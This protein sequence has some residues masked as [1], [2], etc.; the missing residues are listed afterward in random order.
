MTLPV[1]SVPKFEIK[2]PG[3]KTPIS[4]RP[5]LVKE[6]KIL[7]MLKDADPNEVTRQ[8][9]D[10]VETCSF[11]AIKRDAPYYAI[12]YAFTQLRAKSIGEEVALQIECGVNGC[13]EKYNHTMNLSDTL[14]E[15]T[16]RDPKINLGGS[17]G[18]VL[19]FPTFEESVKV[20]ESKDQLELYTLLLSL[21]RAVYTDDTYIEVSDVSPQEFNQFCESLSSEHV[22]QIEDFVRNAPI[23]KN[24]LNSKCPACG[25]E[26]EHSIEGLYLFFV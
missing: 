11:G 23:V 10:L 15:G 14:V 24:K 4:M 7:M 2:V 17:V 12:T 26:H 13:G 25:T 19:R 18:V 1:I 9:A 8:V 21:I 20:F 6:H 3:Y 22:K 16:P 5:F